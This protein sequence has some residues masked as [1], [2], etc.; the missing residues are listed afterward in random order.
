[1]ATET[2][3]DREPEAPVDADTL[4]LDAI[5]AWLLA[6]PAGAR[7]DSGI[8]AVEIF[9]GRDSHLADPWPTQVTW[10]TSDERLSATQFEYVV[11]PAGPRVPPS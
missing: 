11:W 7:A 4:S 9:F 1:M 10:H 2:V 3:I 5:A 8:R 6:K